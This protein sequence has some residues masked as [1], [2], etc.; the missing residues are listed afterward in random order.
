M[1]TCTSNP[2]VNSSPK[3]ILKNNIIIRLALDGALL[4]SSDSEAFLLENWKNLALS[5]S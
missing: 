4:T 2:G 1:A 3:I 5:M